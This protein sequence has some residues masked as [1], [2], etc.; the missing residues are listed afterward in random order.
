MWDGMHD[1]D[2]DIESSPRHAATR[3]DNDGV[4]YLAFIERV[5]VQI[6]KGLPRMKTTNP[7][8]HACM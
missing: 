1:V 5:C 8:I 6:E 2:A 7:G 4:R 3:F